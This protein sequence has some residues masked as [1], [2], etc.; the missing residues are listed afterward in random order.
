MLA[1]WW[2]ELPSWLSGRHP[3]LAVSGEF[4]LDQDTYQEISGK[5]ETDED[6]DI[7]LLS[8][9]SQA[10]EGRSPELRV[11]L[12]IHGPENGVRR[13][14]YRFAHSETRLFTW[15]EDED[16]ANLEK[17]L[18]V[19]ASASIAHVTDISLAVVVNDP[20]EEFVFPLPIDLN[21]SPVSG[22]TQIKG[23]RLAQLDPDDPTQELYSAILDLGD[24]PEAKGS[25]SIYTT[26]EAPFQT[27][28]LTVALE[29]AIPVIML[30]LQQV[31][32]S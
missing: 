16:T 5:I 3:R 21:G 10:D 15:E 4:D 19:L 11:S 8:F 29:R 17:I 9:F 1:G 22:F 2:P 25:A 24:G 12:G 23:V 18:P 20:D 32:E 31:A 28:L 13:V 27:S 14:H 30:T 7:H 26:I 6:G